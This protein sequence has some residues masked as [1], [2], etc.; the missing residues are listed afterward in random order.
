MRAQIRIQSCTREVLPSVNEKQVSE[1]SEI[2]N[3]ESYRKKI[4]SSVFIRSLSR[5]AKNNIPQTKN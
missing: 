4:I 5:R 3:L 2:E 1:V